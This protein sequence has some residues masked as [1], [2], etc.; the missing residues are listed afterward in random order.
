[1]IDNDFSYWNAARARYWPSFYL[2]DKQGMIRATFVGRTNSGSPQAH[3][4]E[5]A[6]D[7]LLAE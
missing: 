3:R 7:G 4:I 6:I 5:Q 2:I 1:M